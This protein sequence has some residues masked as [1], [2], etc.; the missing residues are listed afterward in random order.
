M[1][2]TLLARIKDKQ[3][4]KHNEEAGI[5]TEHVY[6]LCSILRILH[7]CEK[8]LIRNIVGFMAFHLAGQ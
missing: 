8:F 7:Y 1:N 2:G 3:A 5:V 4:N 6:A